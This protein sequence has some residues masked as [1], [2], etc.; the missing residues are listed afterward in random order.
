MDLTPFSTVYLELNFLI[1]FQ[2]SGKLGPTGGLM[3][4]STQNLSSYSFFPL[5]SITD[6]IPFNSGYVK[7][8]FSTNFSGLSYGVI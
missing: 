6:L 3:G 8:N 5:N 1:I 4:V 7:F 2:G